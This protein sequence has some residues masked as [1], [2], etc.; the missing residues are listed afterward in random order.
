MG[1]NNAAARKGIKNTFEEEEL[2]YYYDHYSDGDCGF[3]TS[4]ECVW[5]PE[6][7]EGE[8]T[9]NLANLY[10]HSD[11]CD[12]WDPAELFV[13]VL[14][15]EAL[16]HD[17]DSNEDNGDNG[18][19]DTVDEII[20]GMRGL[21]VSTR[22]SLTPE[23]VL[24]LQL[25][26]HVI[27]AGSTPSALKRL[28]V[29]DD[30]TDVSPCIGKL[31]VSTNP[32]PFTPKKSPIKSW[33]LGAAGELFVFERLKKFQNPALGGFSLNNWM[34]RLRTHVNLHHEYQDMEDGRPSLKESLFSENGDFEYHD[35]LGSFTEYLIR[36]GHLEKKSWK[37]KKPTYYFE[38][39]STGFN[40]NAPF[41]M[42]EKQYEKMKE[43]F[44]AGDKVYII[45]R[46]FNMFTD[47]IDMMLYVN[48][49]EEKLEF[50]RRGS[51]TARYE[52][53]PSRQ[54]RKLWPPWWMESE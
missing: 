21:G 6:G 39:K 5:G 19:D 34:S 41:I 31:H 37:N 18:E 53:H 54:V 48:P 36:Q 8:F 12:G 40:W 33:H 47:K 15:V 29:R 20:A 27:D 26:N 50:T 30:M 52:V 10:D 17:W 45:C 25:L 35:N 2:I 23:E 13:D 22:R 38:V 9:I 44:A 11:F 49:S 16:G 43:I 51:K 24:Y 46:V 1:L 32:L 4:T 14:G 28:S 42:S 3:F 7:V